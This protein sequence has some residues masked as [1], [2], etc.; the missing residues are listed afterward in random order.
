MRPR[1]VALLHAA[2]FTDINMAERPEWH[3]LRTRVYQI[4]L[5]LGDPGDDIALAD[6]QDEARHRL[7]LAGLSRRVVITCLRP[8]ERP[9]PTP[10]PATRA[11]YR[12]LR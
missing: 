5:D 6:L 2:G 1:E 8:A 3:A 7:P 12:S 10:R 11:S 4:A 9:Q